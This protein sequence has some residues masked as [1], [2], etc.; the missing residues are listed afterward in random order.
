MKELKVGS[1]SADDPIG[2]RADNLNAAT[3]QR[4]SFQGSATRPW[5]SDPSRQLRQ[6][7]AP[8]P[9]PM[10]QMN[11]DKQTLL[12][13][14]V[15]TLLPIFLRSISSFWCSKG[16]LPPGY[17]GAAWGYSDEGGR[18]LNVEITPPYKRTKRSQPDILDAIFN[19]DGEQN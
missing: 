15:A 4:S 12:C 2:D 17:V 3:D 16:R 18:Y 11:T 10:E 6:V 7:A 19:N 1:N 5:S 13:L 9:S 8:N 14:S